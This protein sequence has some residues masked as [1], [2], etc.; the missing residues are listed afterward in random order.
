MAFGRTGCE[1]FAPTV[2][3]PPLICTDSAPATSQISMTVEPGSIWLGVATN[4]WIVRVSG[5]VS[6][7]ARPQPSQ[8]SNK[9]KTAEEPDR[10]II[11]R[12]YNR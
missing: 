1:P 12:H 8:S 7:S 5:P 2:P 4:F 10:L 6:L 9:T 11:K 3:T